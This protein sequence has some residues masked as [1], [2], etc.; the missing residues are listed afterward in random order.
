MWEAFRERLRDLG[1]MEGHNVGFVS[2]W[3]HGKREGLSDLTAELVRL[4]VEVIVVGGTPAA[5]A[6]KQ[7]TSTIPIVGSNLSSLLLDGHR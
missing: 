3:A 4:K 5:Q 1:Y 7:A 6:A 2:R